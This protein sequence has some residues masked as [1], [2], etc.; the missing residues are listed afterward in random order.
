MESKSAEAS[1]CF[2]P[3]KIP[4]ECHESSASAGTVSFKD[5]QDLDSKQYC[6]QSQP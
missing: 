1:V 5:L 3:S 6:F 4:S 2:S